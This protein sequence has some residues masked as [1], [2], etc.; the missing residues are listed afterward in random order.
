MK[1]KKWLAL[2]LTIAMAGSV[3]SLVAC[4]E[5]Q[6]D[7]PPPTPPI[8]DEI[9]DDSHLATPGLEF[10]EVYENG[11]FVGYSVGIGTATEAES[12]YV[13]AIWEGERVVSVGVEP[14]TF[15]KLMSEADYYNM[16]ADDAVAFM[17]KY[18][19]SYT[20]Y[21]Q[22]ITLPDTLKYL[23]YGAF[24]NC[25]SLQEITIPKNITAINDYTFMY[26][27]SLN[28]V[29]FQSNDKLESIGASAFLDC[30]SLSTITLPDSVIEIGDS[31]FQIDGAVAD[32]VQT[33]DLHGLSSIDLGASVSS[34]GTEAFKGSGLTSISL[35]D[36]V[37]DI[38]ESAFTECLFLESAR[39]GSGVRVV[40]EKMFRSCGALTSVYMTGVRKIEEEAF[41][42]CEKLASVYFGEYLES[43]GY[44]AFWACAALTK[45]ELPDTIQ[46]IANAAFQTCR[47]LEEVT[48]GANIWD[49][50]QYAFD[51]GNGAMP[52]KI[53]YNGTEA[54]YAHVGGAG[55]PMAGLVTFLK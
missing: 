11:R 35:P 8:D 36:S 39:L 45:V 5:G 12:I 13:P 7:P 51:K 29:T 53:Y 43:I 30:I 15:S 21:L 49:I 27:I 6:K 2:G 47:S 54:E 10:T 52:S 20:E 55:K 14:N 26:D 28:K 18:T 41:F 4:D 32:W 3:F 19:I 33:F 48:L 37:S 40:P 23:G 38:G 9:E 22:S 25:L 50:G 1:L 24:V 17:Q 16:D 42:G 44:A 34:I 46:T 31:A